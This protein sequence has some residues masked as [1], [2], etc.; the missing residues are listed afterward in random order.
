MVLS[1]SSFVEDPEQ[2]KV[3]NYYFDIREAALNIA[4]SF[5]GYREAS[6]N[7]KNYIYDEVRKAVEGIYKEGNN[8][9]N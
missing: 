1:I 6:R 5:P 7:T 2:R 4:Y 8:D 3:I 9:K